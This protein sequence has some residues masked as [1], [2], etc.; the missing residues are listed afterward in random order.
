MNSAAKM[1]R[2]AIIRAG[3]G[4]G[5]LDGINV[6]AMIAKMRPPEVML[7]GYLTANME[8]RAYDGVPTGATADVLR[9]L[10]RLPR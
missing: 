8:K 3:D 6:V 4:A 7:P 10:D 1:Q 5:L 2:L 9:L